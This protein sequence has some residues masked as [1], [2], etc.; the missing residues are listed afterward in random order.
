MTSRKR[1]ARRRPSHWIVA[2][3]VCLVALAAPAVAQAGPLVASAPNCD[4]Q[5]L[6]RPFLPWLDVAK[7]TL[8]SGGDF[9]NGASGWSLNGASVAEGNESFDVGGAADSRSLNVPSGSSATSST[10]CVGLDH[11][12]IRFFARNTGSLLGTLKVE[13]LFEDAS[14]DVHNLLIGTAVG[15]SRWQPTLPMPVVANLLP[16]LPGDM[17]PVQFRFTVQGGNWSID[18]VYVDPWRGR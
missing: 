17:T 10:I 9:E 5:Q 13:V 8:N 15:G 18:D 4:D 11:P 7:Y 6:S 12:D 3:A 2:A 1:V 14:G 16:L